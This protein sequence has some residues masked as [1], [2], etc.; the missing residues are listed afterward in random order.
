MMKDPINTCI[1]CIRI[2]KLQV[3]KSPIST[4][5]EVDKPVSETTSWWYVTLRPLRARQAT[6]TEK[7]A[8][9]GGLCKPLLFSASHPGRGL[10]GSIARRH[11]KT[12]RTHRE[13]A[14]EIPHKTG[15][16]NDR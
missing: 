2:E 7:R 10:S 5:A 1:S 16:L 14:D 3:T 12:G 4:H 11:S 15:Y 6:T 8:H 9:S 13:V